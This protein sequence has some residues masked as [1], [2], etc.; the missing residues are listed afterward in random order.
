MLKVIRDFVD[1]GSLE[2][3]DAATYRFMRTVKAAV[4][5]EW[6][7]LKKSAAG[8][9]P[10]IDPGRPWG[11]QTKRVLRL[12]EAA[13]RMGR[14]RDHQAA[15]DLRELA[16]SLDQNAHTVLLKAAELVRRNPP[17]I[18][19]LQVVASNL[20]DTVTTI[21]RFVRRAE[22]TM[23]EIERDLDERRAGQSGD[24]NLEDVAA[25]V[26]SVLGRLE[27]AVGELEK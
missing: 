17:F 22:Q 26:L 13:H 19:R 5:I 18:E 8:A 15:Q 9:A 3:P 23:S 2:S 21:S 24:E 16:T 4:E 6:R 7:S 10:S 14:L 12:V 1:T 25:D 27:E 11:E 20:P